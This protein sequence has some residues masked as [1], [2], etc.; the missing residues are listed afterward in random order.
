M[1]LKSYSRVRSADGGQDSAYV[2]TIPV[3]S[4]WTHD[5]LSILS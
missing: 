1:G 4:V 2:T 3:V 5:T